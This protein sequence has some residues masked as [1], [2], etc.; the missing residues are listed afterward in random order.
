MISAC[1]TNLKARLNKARA[2][3]FGTVTQDIAVPFNLQ[4]DCGSPI[5][6]VRR[7]SWQIAT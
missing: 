7:V 6:G 1:M 5:N 3:L 4:C 2:R